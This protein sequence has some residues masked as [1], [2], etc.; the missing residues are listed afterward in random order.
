MRSTWTDDGL[1]QLPQ[2]KALGEPIP[3]ELL[4]DQS[5][6]HGAFGNGRFEVSGL[7]L[8]MPGRWE[9]YFDIGRGAIIERAQVDIDLD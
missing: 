4:P 1:I 5:L 8:H 7:R 2:V 6:V 9:I 3:K